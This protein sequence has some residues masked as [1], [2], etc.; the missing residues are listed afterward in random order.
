MKKFNGKPAEILMIE[1]NEGDILL[2]REAFT[3][4]KINNELHVVED[5]EEALA[6]LNKESPYENA[7][8]PD[9]ILLDINLPKIDGIEVLVQIKSNKKLMRI[10][11]IMLSSSQSDHD[12]CKTY[13]L[14]ANGYIVKPIDYQKFLDVVNAIEHFWFTIVALPDELAEV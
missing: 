3:D 1:D 8:T 2:A 9:L 4:S 7:V 11:V 12:M 10:P 5:G 14:H 6:F 13:G